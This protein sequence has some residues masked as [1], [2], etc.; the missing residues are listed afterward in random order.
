M[1]TPVTD[2]EIESY[3][4]IYNKVKHYLTG[5][6]DKLAYII[7]R[8]VHA[9]GDPDICKYI[10]FSSNLVEAGLRAIQDRRPV[11][12]DVNMVT[13]G[14]KSRVR[15][16]GL[17][18]YTVA[19]YA[20]QDTGRTPRMSGA[21][22]MLIERVPEARDAIFVIGCSP[23]VLSEL[24]DLAARGEVRPRLVI[25]CPPGF[26]NAP[27][28]KRRLENSGLPYLTVRETRGGSPIAV[29]AINSIIDLYTGRAET[30]LHLVKMCERTS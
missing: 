30:V 12:A 1:S 6:D 19:E 5:L 22:R 24:L 21:M 13:A 9:T 4:V 29:A 3:R 23:I 10:A 28:A 7:I 2:I 8:I 14:I 11:V 15:S 25:G 16:V 18:L 20:G 26:I 27:E 17:N